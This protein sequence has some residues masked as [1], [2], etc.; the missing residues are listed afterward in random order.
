MLISQP[1]SWGTD[2][3]TALNCVAHANTIVLHN[4]K[5]EQSL[6][7][8]VERFEASSTGGSSRPT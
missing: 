3:A 1:L 2:L 7:D 5:D 8:A 6:I 4:Y